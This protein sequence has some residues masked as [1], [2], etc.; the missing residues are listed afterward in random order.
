MANQE[1]E[2]EVTISKEDVKNTRDF[3]QH[4]NIN[5]PEY[6]NSVLTQIENASEITPELQF[7]M[8]VQVARSMVENREHELLKD[9]LFDEVIPNC[10]KVWFDQQFQ[11]DFENA[12]V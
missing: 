11:E 5:M 9:Q 6:L 10:E 8:K 12:E 3:F 2:N 1:N 7:E 4:F